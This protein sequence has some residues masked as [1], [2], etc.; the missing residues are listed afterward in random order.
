MA[1]LIQTF[2]GLTSRISLANSFSCG[3][4]DS[5]GPPPSLLSATHGRLGGHS[6]PSVNITIGSQCLAQTHFWLAAP[7][8]VRSSGRGCQGPAPRATPS[9]RV[10]GWSVSRVQPPGLSKGS[11]GGGKRR[12]RQGGTQRLSVHWNRAPLCHTCAPLL[13][14]TAPTGTQHGQ[15]SG[16][17]KTA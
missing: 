5:P 14:C 1:S 10:W 8:D 15:L 2:T 12:E 11:T 13:P 4:S 16:P 7:R 6:K 17:H 9:D 3:S